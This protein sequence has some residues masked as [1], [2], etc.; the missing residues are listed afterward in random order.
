MN[1]APRHLH[2][3]NPAEQLRL[4]REVKSHPHIKE[5]GNEPVLHAS[6]KLSG[7]FTT[8]EILQAGDELT[9]TIANADGEVIA[10]GAAEC[11]YPKFGAI[12]LQGEVVGEER[13][14]TAK[15]G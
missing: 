15:L 8:K 14:T 1:D 5:M 11:G 9:V 12:K 2:A 13:V 7:A 6:I 10:T 3:V 4:F